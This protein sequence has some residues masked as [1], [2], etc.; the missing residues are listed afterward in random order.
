M[1]YTTHADCDLIGLGMSA[2]SHVGDSFSQN[3]RDLPPWEVGRR[4]GRL[5]VWRGM[6]LDADD[7]MLRARSHSAAHVPGR[8]ASTAQIERRHEIDFDAYFAE[9]IARLLPL[10]ADGLVAID[11]RRHCRDLARPAAAAY[12]RHVLRP[13]PQRRSPLR[14]TQPRYSRV[15]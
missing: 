14:E 10:A 15:I 4:Q 9:A 12:H 13:L 6:R 7:D 2:I 5:P 11:G 8:V 1:G 3:A